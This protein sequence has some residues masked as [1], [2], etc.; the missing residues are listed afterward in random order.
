MSDAVVV[1]VGLSIGSYILKAAGPLLLGGRTLPPTLQSLAEFAPAAM[2]AA[3]VVVS[4]LGDGSSI[5]VDARAAGVVAAGVALWRRVPF[6]GVVIAAS[7]ATALA[8]ALAG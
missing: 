2:L 3:L 4:T 7:T 8:R 1:L 5:S 6:I